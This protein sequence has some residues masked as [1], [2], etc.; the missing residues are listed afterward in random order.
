MTD[1][2]VRAWAA[3]CAAA[4][5]GKVAESLAWDQLAVRGREFPLAAGKPHGWM[6]NRACFGNAAL[7]ALAGEVA[8]EDGEWTY[9]E[10]FALSHGLWYHHAWVVNA[11]GEAVDPTWDELGDRYVGVTFGSGCF[12]YQPGGCQLGRHSFGIAFGPDLEAA[13]EEVA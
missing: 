13:Q 5:R 1:A 3:R 6:E 4:T 7:T 9:A 11:D 10:G 2:E 12:P 8:G